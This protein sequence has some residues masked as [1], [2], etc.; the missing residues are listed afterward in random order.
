MKRRH[1]VKRPLLKSSAPNL[2]FFFDKG[3][4]TKSIIFQFL[5]TNSKSSMAL[6]IVGRHALYFRK[7]WWLLLYT[8]RRRSLT[9]T[10]TASSLFFHLRVWSLRVWSAAV[11]KTTPIWNRTLITCA[12]LIYQRNIYLFRMMR[13]VRTKISHIYKQKLHRLSDLNN[14]LKMYR[15]GVN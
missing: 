6:E 1:L 10:A 7:V 5:Q 12:N 13:K 9:G 15:G 4:A 2:S 3:L 8:P 14:A 11:W